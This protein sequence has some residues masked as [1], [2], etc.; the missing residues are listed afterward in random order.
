M[1]TT[2]LDSSFR[3]ILNHHYA[4]LF[5]ASSL[6]DQIGSLWSI[7]GYQ[8]FTE[9]LPTLS[10]HLDEARQLAFAHFA[11]ELCKVVMLCSSYDFF[12]NLDSNPLG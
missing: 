8:L 7:K 10:L 11:L 6:E 4:L 1:P 3:C 12:L 2:K 9:D 5:L